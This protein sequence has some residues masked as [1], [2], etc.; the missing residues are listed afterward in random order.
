MIPYTTIPFVSAFF[1]MLVGVLI[2]QLF[3]SHFRTKHQRAIV[4][5]RRRLRQIRLELKQNADQ[6][7]SLSG[8]LSAAGQRGAEQARELD[9]LRQERDLLRCTQHEMTDR[10]SRETQARK[11][12]AVC[13]EDERQSHDA[14]TG[15]VELLRQRAAQ[16]QAAYEQMQ[17]QLTAAEQHHRSLSQQLED[18]QLMQQKRLS[19]SQEQLDAAARELSVL[20]QRCADLHREKQSLSEELLEASESRRQLSEEL[21]AS[22]AA[23]ASLQTLAAD[24]HQDRELAHRWKSEA[25]RLSSELEVQNAEVQRLIDLTRSLREEIECAVVFRKQLEEEQRALA[26]AERNL[27]AEIDRERSQREQLEAASDRLRSQLDEARREVDRLALI[28]D[29][30]VEL[31]AQNRQAT[32]ELKRLRRER[33]DALQVEATTRQIVGELR[34]ELTERL[35]EVEL[36]RRDKDAAA[37]QLEFERRQRRQIEEALDLSESRLTALQSEKDGWSDRQTKL[38]AQTTEL[39]EQ[40]RQWQMHAH[41]FEQRS[42]RA[43]RQV[44]ELARQLDNQQQLADKM[45]R[46][47]FVASEPE[48]SAEGRGG[49]SFRD[50]RIREPAGPDESSEVL[51]V[52]PHTKQRGEPTAPRPDDLK[53]IPGIADRVEEQL[54]RLG[55]FTYRQMMEWD[56]KAIAQ[57]SRRLGLG[58]LVERHDW[59]NHARRLYY[60]SESHVA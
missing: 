2:G 58:D 16:D 40:V 33:D 20:S 41:E 39:T 24:R 25:A 51:A 49:F 21:E 31:E 23:Q 5:L 52:E 55:V 45:R 13:L 10:L 9:Q 4:N 18:A 19:A 59:V 35:D 57:I 8:Q 34:D 3:W 44:A 14:A 12:L 42:Q 56:R 50:M 27:S 36:L 38:I 11:D 37:H 29:R 48:T 53:K 26:G 17:R 7:E 32:D 47:R 22:R 60:E 1:L 30:S 46:R 15:Q 43:E 28:E 6:L 54:H